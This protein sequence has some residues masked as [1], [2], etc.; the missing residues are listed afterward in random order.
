MNNTPETPIP[1]LLGLLGARAETTP[2]GVPPGLAPIVG[3][4]PQP[5]GATQDPSV[6]IN[7][8]SRTDQY[9]ND[10]ARVVSGLTAKLEV[11]E[12]NMY[13]ERD[14]R[15]MQQARDQ[16]RASYTVRPSTGEESE[17]NEEPL[18]RTAQILHIQKPVPEALIIS[19]ISLPA[20]RKLQENQK[21]FKHQTNQQSPLTDFLTSHLLRLFV[22]EEKRKG[23]LGGRLLTYYNIYDISDREVINIM[24]SYI[25]SRY[26]MT[27]N[28]FTKVLFHSVR[29]LKSRTEGWTFGI[30]QYHMELHSEVTRIIYE[31]TISLDHLY[32]DATEAE[33]RFWPAMNLGHKEEY[34]VFRIL[35][36]VLG[37]FAKSFEW[38]IG[39]ALL[40]SMKSAKEFLLQLSSVNDR[41][42]DQAIELES[43]N[44]A[45][46]PPMSLEKVQEAYQYRQKASEEL[47]QMVRARE[48][49]YRGLSHPSS[50]YATPSRVLTRGEDYQSK[51]SD[52]VGSDRSSRF[53]VKSSGYDRN[54]SMTPNDRFRTNTRLNAL[55]EEEEEEEFDF[56]RSF[57]SDTTTGYADIKQQRVVPYLTLLWNGSKKSPKLVQNKVQTW[58]TLVNARRQVLGSSLTQKRRSH[59]TPSPHALRPFT[60][61]TVPATAAETIQRR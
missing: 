55:E 48:Q 21:I 36:G 4:Q 9:V 41:Y 20:M 45:S 54:Q 16:R 58:L 5:L 37:P 11:M 19:T 7:N 43:Q 12:M 50:S 31:I 28:G 52:S 44:A 39:T 24:S 27:R 23:S 53:G 42:A 1:G 30:S 51:V 38:V 59:Q 35:L 17:D 33:K 34:G 29:I 26:A 61:V 47:G 13:M 2:L 32:K 46:I 3:S 22:D 57:L 49:G 6:F 10:L 15:P 40:K 60:M 25:R 56:E 18:V 14:H 8:V